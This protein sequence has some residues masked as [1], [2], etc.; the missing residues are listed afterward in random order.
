[1]HAVRFVVV[2][3]RHLLAADDV[4]GPQ[5]QVLDPVD[6]DDTAP[7]HLHAQ[8]RGSYQRDFASAT[9]LGDTFPPFQPA[10]S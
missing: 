5:P 9:A 10:P 7:R 4:L 8:R 6:L 3:L 2:L 1:M